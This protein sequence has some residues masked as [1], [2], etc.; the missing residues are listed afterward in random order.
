MIELSNDKLLFSFPSVHPEAKLTISFKR[1]LRLPDDDNVYPLTPDL[2][3]FPLRHVDDFAARVP[4][5]WMEYGGVMLP[6]YQSEAL[7]L[8]FDPNF[9]TGRGNY[10]FAIRV[11]TGKID[12][13]TGEE[14]RPGLRRT[15]DYKPGQNYMISPGQP[16]LDGYCVR[17][18]TVRQFVAMPLGDD[19]SAE[20]QI[21]GTAE[22]GG[23]QIIV[24]PM[25]RESFDRH[26]P[27]RSQALGREGSTGCFSSFRRLSHLAKPSLGMAPGGKMKQ[28]IYKDEF[29]LLD[30]DQSTSSRCFVHLANSQVWKN[31]T[32][33]A[34]PTMPISAK[35]YTELGLPWFDY[36]DESRTPL[37]SSE[38]LANLT[39]V[40][41]MMSKN[42]G[43]VIAD[44]A[45]CDPEYI[46]TFHKQNPKKNQ[47]REF[48]F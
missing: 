15:E 17:R 39:S 29:D 22:Y 5:Q 1:T 40:S 46:I 8:R 37:S 47:V 9:V 31:I 6:M 30:W 28:H 14:Y 18:G 38:V 36:Y 19:Y 13:I 23:M 2:G 35:K 33:D 41:T 20:E 32:G 26:F 43:H 44:N 24:Y 48:N 27:D 25:K 45:S 10:P 3:D 34:P 11:L 21:T 7:W 12:V 4:T 16:W 42:F